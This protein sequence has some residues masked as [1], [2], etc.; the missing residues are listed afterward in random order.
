MTCW[1]RA[2]LFAHAH[3]A[4]IKLAEQSGMLIQRGGERSAFPHRVR[5]LQHHGAQ[6]WILLLLAQAFQG[7][8]DG[9][10][11]AE[12]RAHLARERRDF[13]SP[14]ALPERLLQAAGAVAVAVGAAA[15]PFEAEI[16]DVE[17]NSPRRPS[18]WRAVLRSS[19]SITPCTGAPLASMAW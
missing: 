19:A 6:G 12:Q 14:D 1:Q 13:L 4:D 11:R 18:S 15:P 8:R 3:H 16:P 10:G 17:G 5:N 2:G 9:N 7:L